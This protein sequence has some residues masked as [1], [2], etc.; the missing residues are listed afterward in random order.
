M[1]DSNADSDPASSFTKKASKKSIASDL[2]FNPIVMIR[3]HR[4]QQSIL[5]GFTGWQHPKI[6]LLESDLE[7]GDYWR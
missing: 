7:V 4:H 6:L 3:L 1:V 5:V 2:G